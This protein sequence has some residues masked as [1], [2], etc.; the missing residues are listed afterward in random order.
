MYVWQAVTVK[1]GYVGRPF[2]R[3]TKLN[4]VIK[5]YTYLTNIICDNSNKIAE[6]EIITTPTTKK[7]KVF[8]KFL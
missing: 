7:L 2:N 1:V 3:L 4:K 5:I 6:M 8:S